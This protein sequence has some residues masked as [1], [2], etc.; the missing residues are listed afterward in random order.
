MPPYKLEFEPINHNTLRNK[1]VTVISGRSN[2][3]TTIVYQNKA[4]GL[5]QNPCSVLF[6]FLDFC[7]GVSIVSFFGPIFLEIFEWVIS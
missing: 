5:K 6:H 1:N 7:L 3:E 2:F 4:R